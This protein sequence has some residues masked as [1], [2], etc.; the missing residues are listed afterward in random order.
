M[1]LKE[2]NFKIEDRWF[3]NEEMTILEGIVISSETEGAYASSIMEILDKYL[4]KKC[5]INLNNLD[6]EGLNKLNIYRNVAI[7]PNVI[8]DGSSTKEMKELF[9]SF[10][11]EYGEAEIDAKTV[12]FKISPEDNK[13]KVIYFMTDAINHQV[14]FSTYY[15]SESFFSDDEFRYDHRDFTMDQAIEMIN[16]RDKI[17]S[18]FDFL[19]GG[20]VGIKRNKLLPERRN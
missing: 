14:K 8:G 17:D 2:I 19:S 1:K 6:Y 20:E 11:E 9:S 10:L 7:S 4:N 3:S 5:D 16:S 12:S 18:V 13:D 15:L